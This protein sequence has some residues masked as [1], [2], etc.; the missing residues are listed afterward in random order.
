MLNAPAN[1]A[2]A[3]AKL[4]DAAGTQLRVVWNDN[5]GLATQY[6]VEYREAGSDEWTFVGVRGRGSQAQTISDFTP[7]VAYE[8]R[9]RAENKYGVSEWTTSSVATMAAPTV[10]LV[11]V[12]A[13]AL[14][15]SLASDALATNMRVEIST[16]PFETESKI[17]SANLFRAVTTGAGEQ[18]R[19]FGNLEAGATYYVR[20]LAINADGVSAW[21]EVLEVV[22]PS[23]D[24]VSEAF[25]DIFAEDGEDDFWFEFEKATGARK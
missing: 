10:E 14:T 5:S 7:G 19:S 20:V 6:R 25:A 13:A 15:L 1:V 17:S 23:G 9:V 4:L 18:T 2:G 16:T 3:Q 24:A 8:V 22:V 21:S 11:S 12:D